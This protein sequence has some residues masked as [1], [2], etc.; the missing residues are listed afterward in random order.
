MKNTN[1]NVLKLLHN[2]LDDLWRIEKHYLKDAKKSKCGCPG[3]LKTMRADL[4]KNVEMLKKEL[5]T[6]HK[7][8]KLA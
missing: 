5:G 3:I 1:Y 2:Q 4:K 7:M 8:D 6:H